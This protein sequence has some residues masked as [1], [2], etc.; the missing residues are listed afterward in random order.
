MAIKMHYP[1]LSGVVS[2]EDVNELKR[3]ETVIVENA[4]W[5]LDGYKDC[6]WKYSE[7]HHG[8]S[9]FK[10]LKNKHGFEIGE[11]SI[12]KLKSLDS[13]AFLDLI[14]ERT[15]K[16]ALAE[17]KKKHRNQESGKCQDES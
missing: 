7:T 11:V 5:L 17:N 8:N 1:E 6:F 10:L 12:L 15:H 3:F 16:S 9:Y 4:S 13:E 2:V 14:K